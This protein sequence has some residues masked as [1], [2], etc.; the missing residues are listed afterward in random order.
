MRVLR[1]ALCV[2]VAMLTVGVFA[3]SS[4]GQAL[5]AE[6]SIGPATSRAARI[7]GPR[8]RILADDGSRVTSTDGAGGR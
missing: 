8:L 7:P 4:F 1:S 2:C 5:P 3:G 6:K